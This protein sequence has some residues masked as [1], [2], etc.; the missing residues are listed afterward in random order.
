MLQQVY[1]TETASNDLAD[2]VRTPHQHAY[3]LQLARRELRFPPLAGP[4]EDWVPW[5]HQAMAWRRAIEHS[6]AELVGQGFGSD[7]YE[8]MEEFGKYYYIYRKPKSKEVSQASR[9]G[10]RPD[11]SVARFLTIDQWIG[12]IRYRER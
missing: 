9:D 4:D 2:V 11:L 12:F 3:L 10:I 8:G 6:I 5:D 7:P 1:W